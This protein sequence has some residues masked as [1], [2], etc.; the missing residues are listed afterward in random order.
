MSSIGQMMC[1][2]CGEPFQKGNVVVTFRVWP[3]EE[4]VGHAACVISLS[5]DEP[6]PEDEEFG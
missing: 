2:V 5:I 1:S 6:P 3:N 4:K